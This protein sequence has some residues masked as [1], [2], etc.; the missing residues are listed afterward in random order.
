MPT[1]PLHRLHIA[2]LVIDANSLGDLP[3]EQLR[4]DVAA[5]LAARLS[6]PLA[7]DQAKPG[8]AQQIAA[9]ATPRIRMQLPSRRNGG[10][11]GPV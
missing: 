11:D 9:A 3:P 5:A 2:R 4:T 6:D 1:P 10:L 8:L 7:A